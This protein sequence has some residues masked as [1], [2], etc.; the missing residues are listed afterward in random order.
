[1]PAGHD[2]GAANQSSVFRFAV[3]ILASITSAAR[4]FAFRK[5][6]LGNEHFVSAIT[7]YFPQYFIFRIHMGSNTDISQKD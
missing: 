2:R 1:M 3:E 4:Y 5:I 6:V 7:F